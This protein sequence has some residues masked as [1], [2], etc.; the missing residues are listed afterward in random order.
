LLRQVEDDF[1]RAR[2]LARVNYLLTRP[3]AGRRRGDLRVEE[4]YLQRIVE[5]L[6]AMRRT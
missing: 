5:R 3:A 2:L 6:N 1:E 4:A